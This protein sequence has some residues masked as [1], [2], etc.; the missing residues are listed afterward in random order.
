MIPIKT[1]STINIE[2][3]QI[4]RLL[5]ILLTIGTFEVSLLVMK[6]DIGLCDITLYDCYSLIKYFIIR[7][8]ISLQIAEFLIEFLIVYIYHRN[9]NKITSS[10]K[11]DIDVEMKTR[12]KSPVND[13]SITLPQLLN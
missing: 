2:E 9:R 8:S 12:V 6:Y 13:A 5:V 11:K 3:C 7:L 10:T 4:S 1:L